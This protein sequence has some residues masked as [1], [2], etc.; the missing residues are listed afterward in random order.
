MTVLSNLEI[1]KLI[2]QGKLIKNSSAK[3]VGAACYELRAGKTY[4]DLTENNSRTDLSQREFIIIKP[5]HRVVILTQ[6]S[7]E[8]PN[9]ILARVVSKGSL[10]SIGLSAVCT[11]ADPGF[12]GQLGIVTQNFSDKYIKISPGQAIAKIDFS[13]LSSESTKPYN[14]QHGFQSNF[15]PIDTTLQKQHSE[16]ASDS[17]VDSE[18]DEAYKVLPKDVSQVIES[19]VRKQ[20]RVNTGIIALFAINAL[21]LV[22]AV[23][24]SK[25]IDTATAI[26]INLISQI[27]VSAFTF[28]RRAK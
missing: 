3:Q 17:R 8:I 11:Q 6:E 18:L 22:F 21:T 28:L 19:L 25:P 23:L 15:W 4:F 9:D 26:I 12:K 13:F 16:V 14:G 10:F 7:L 1:E 2:A 24:P 20:R 27:L 5:W